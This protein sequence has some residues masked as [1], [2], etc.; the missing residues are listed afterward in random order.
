MDVEGA[1]RNRCRQ[2]GLRIRAPISS[3][4]LLCLEPPDARVQ[5]QADQMF[6]LTRLDMP[7]HLGRPEPTQEA[8]RACYTYIL[9]CSK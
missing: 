1:Q 2:E 4:F 9:S 3:S 6:G 5:A 8:E 7:R